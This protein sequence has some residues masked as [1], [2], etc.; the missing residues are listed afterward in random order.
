MQARKGAFLSRCGP[1]LDPLA[2]PYQ[3]HLLQLT[4]KATHCKEQRAQFTALSGIFHLTPSSRG[5]QCQT[6]AT[7]VEPGRAPNPKKGMNKDMSKILVTLALLCASL[8]AQ[9]TVSYDG[10]VR[11]SGCCERSRKLRTSSREKPAEGS[12]AIRKKPRSSEA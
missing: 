11:Q 5:Y 2:A 10:A 12:A 7:R 8:Q 3:E 1:L 4:A 6:A 9:V